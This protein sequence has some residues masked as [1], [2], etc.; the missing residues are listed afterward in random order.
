MKKKN[1]II[2]LVIVAAV[3][4]SGYFGF[5]NSCKDSC[6]NCALKFFNVPIMDLGFKT[7]PLVEENI[8]GGCGGVY[9]IYWDEC[10][11]R[12]FDEQHPFPYER[13][14]GNW[15]VENNSCKWICESDNQCNADEDCYPEGFIP[16]TD[17]G[18][19]YRCEDGKCYEGSSQRSAT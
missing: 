6:G 18:P 10:C 15:T 12:E 17:G 9:Y 2:T 19:F 16:G 4:I 3:I 5:S 13:C 8:V 11:Q 7:C 14:P 1:L